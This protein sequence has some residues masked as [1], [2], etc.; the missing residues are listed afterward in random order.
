MATLMGTTT[1]TARR[2]AARVPFTLA[3]VAG[4]AIAGFTLLSASAPHRAGA[5]T[6]RPHAIDAFII[7]TLSATGIQGEGKSGGPGSIE[8]NSF[9]WGVANKASSS[10][11]GA[12]KVTFNPF[13]ITRKIDSASPLFFKACATGAHLTQVVLFATPP[14]GQSGDSMKITFSN[15]TVSS[16]MITGNSATG[17]EPTESIS[18]I[19]KTYK[20]T[21]AVGPPLT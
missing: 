17:Q 1:R 10:G 5:S 9:Q 2:R 8:V 19:P 21:Y 11:A 7:F 12:G 16:D 18:M 4:L 3:L 20:I 14:A 15:V 6:V 13:S